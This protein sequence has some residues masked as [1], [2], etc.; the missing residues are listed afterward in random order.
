[1]RFTIR[2]RGQDALES[3]SGATVFPRFLFSLADHE[4][5]R[6]Q[7]PGRPSAGPPGRA[8][9]LRQR[10]APANSEISCLVSL[11][12]PSRVRV[13]HWRRRLRAR[14]EGRGGRRAGFAWAGFKAAAARPVGI[15]PGSGAGSGHSVADSGAPGPLACPA[16]GGGRG[17][18]PAA[19]GASESP[20]PALSARHAP[21]RADG[22]QVACPR[23]A[24]V[25]QPGARRR[26]G[27]PGKSAA[28]LAGDLSPACQ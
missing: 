28:A 9:P 22:C 25:P 2:G 15:R 16:L 23:P 11:A 3:C 24:A 10:P 12:G 5:P 13:R 20:P 19:R 27:K 1:M 21:G 14:R 4:T 8:L 17:A 7:V 6:L 18:W 26:R